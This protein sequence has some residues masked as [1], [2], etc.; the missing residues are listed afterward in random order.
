MCTMNHDLLW[1]KILKNCMIKRSQIASALLVAVACVVLTSCHSSRSFIYNGTDV[2]ELV[3]AGNALGFDIELND[4]W[5]LM[6]EASSWLGTPY[7]YGGNTRSGIDCSGLNVAIYK[8]VYN[9][10]LQRNSRQQYETD[11]HKVKQKNLKQGDLVFFAIADKVNASNINHTGI[12]LKNGR[13]IHASTS[14]GV[15]VDQLDTPYYT[16]YWVAGGRVK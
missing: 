8:S 3:R 16:K 11:C 6:L 5:P 10:Q 7:R 2:R 15:V 14:R 12:Y 9:R 1:L 4:N 13:F